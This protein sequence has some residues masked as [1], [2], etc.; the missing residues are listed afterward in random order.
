MS[1]MDKTVIPYGF[2][3][4]SLTECEEVIL[5]HVLTDKSKSKKD[6][7][8]SIEKKTEKAKKYLNENI[9][10]R[11]EILKGD[12]LTEMM[13]LSKKE[14]L[15]LLVVGRKNIVEGTGETSRKL[16]RRALCSILRVP[17]NAKPDFRKILIPIDFS[18]YSKRA[19]ERA[20]AV[21]KREKDIEIICLNIYDLPKGYLQSGK[22]PEEFAEI[23]QENAQRRYNHFIKKFDFEGIKVTPRYQLD[24]NNVKAKIISNIALVEDANLIVMGSRGRTNMAA[25]LLGSTTEKL[26]LHNL[27]IPMLILKKKEQNLGF[28]NALLNI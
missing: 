25:A 6:T 28:F 17:E 9:K 2:R 21:A 20:I 3:A 19:I 23:M 16:S 12:P 1:A 18:E 13:S 14:N 26:L 7:I 24:R 8:A 11:I 15:D 4:A 5:M 27:T 10:V 22:S